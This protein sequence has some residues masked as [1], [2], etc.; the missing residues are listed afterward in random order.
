[1]I[2]LAQQVKILRALH[3][4]DQQDLAARIGVDRRLLSQFENGHTMLNDEDIE[5]IGVIFRELGT[6]PVLTI[7][8][9]DKLAIAA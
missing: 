8:L 7:H 3:N 5:K 1:M 9:S 6:S 2:P 4:L